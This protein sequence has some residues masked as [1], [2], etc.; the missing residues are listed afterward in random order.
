[1]DVEDLTGRGYTARPGSSGGS[2]GVLGAGQGGASANT[3]APMAIKRFGFKSKALRVTSSA[4]SA[5]APAATVTQDEAQQQQ[6]LQQA[7]TSGCELAEIPAGTAP[8]V[9][10]SGRELQEEDPMATRKR[11]AEPAALVQSPLNPAAVM[12]DG[13]KRRT[14]PDAAAGR[15][16]QEGGLPSLRDL[17]GGVEGLAVGGDE[18]RAPQDAAAL[19]RAAAAAAATKLQQQQAAAAAAQR[20][21]MPPPPPCDPAPQGAAGAAAAAATAGE[22]RREPLRSRSATPT[23]QAQQQQQPQ[24]QS[25]QA[26][27]GGGGG[28]GPNLASAPPERLPEPQKRAME[29][30]NWVYVGGLR[31]QK[32][33]CVGRGG[34]SKV[35]K[36][37]RGV[38]MGQGGEGGCGAD[39]SSRLGGLEAR[40]WASLST[41]EQWTHTIF[42]FLTSCPCASPSTHSITT[43]FTNAHTRAHAP[44]QVLGCNRQI[45]ALTR[46]RLINKEPN[47][48]SHH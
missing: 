19:Q 21:Q 2:G 38:F 42:L 13:T 8:G 7:V 5:A 44:L 33:D 43:H 32:L 31:Y 14:S 23:G 34:S 6:L 15:G 36:V 11:R 26:S 39:V 47:T 29:D 25:R 48:P 35:F 9:M 46:V 27:D 10:A 22:E 37:R 28:P 24:S 3:T 1:M 12:P 41:P 30:A 17:R 16:S 4:T 40:V 18:N 20:Q 45:Y